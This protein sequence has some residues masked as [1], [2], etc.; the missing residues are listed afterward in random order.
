MYV[1][2]EKQI[3]NLSINIKKHV[4]DVSLDGND[5]FLDCLFKIE[6]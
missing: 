3:I 2:K 6:D 1:K 5:L 4:L